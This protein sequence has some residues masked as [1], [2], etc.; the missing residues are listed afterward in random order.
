MSA[1][2]RC[3][4]SMDINSAGRSRFNREITICGTCCVVEAR[5]DVLGIQV[6][7]DEWPITVD[8]RLLAEASSDVLATMADVSSILDALVDE[9]A[10]D[11]VGD[12]IEQRADH[13]LSVLRDR[14]RHAGIPIAEE[15]LQ[16]HRGA[17]LDYFRG[18]AG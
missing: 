14:S 7:P 13:A 12:T 15:M 17:Y 16:S 8:D 11:P 10:V 1:C 5:A 6:P 18:R 2:P 3:T 4:R 9:A